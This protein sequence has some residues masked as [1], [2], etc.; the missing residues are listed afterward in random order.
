MRSHRGCGCLCCCL[1]L[2]VA[3]TSRPARAIAIT[4][5]ETTVSAIASGRSAAQIVMSARQDPAGAAADVACGAEVSPLAG[6]VAVDA[7]VA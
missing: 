3:A 7:A 2:A 1:R 6:L 4:A 5:D